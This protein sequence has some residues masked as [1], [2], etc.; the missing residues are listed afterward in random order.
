MP[1]HGFLYNQTQLLK[2]VENTAQA[3]IVPRFT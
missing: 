2:K 1:V 3:Q